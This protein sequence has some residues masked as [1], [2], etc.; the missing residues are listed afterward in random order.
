MRNSHADVAVVM[1]LYDEA[2]SVGGVLSELTETLRPA[3]LGR[4][5][6]VL[7]DDGSTDGSIAAARKTWEGLS[8]GDLRAR[9]HVLRLRAN[10]GNQEALAAGFQYAGGLDCGLIF[11]MDSDGQDDPAAIP[12]MI[13]LLDAH[14]IVFAARSR[15]DEPLLWRAGYT[16]YRLVFR[17]LLGVDFPYGN[18]SG[19]RAEVLDFV[20]E[21]GT[22]RH[23]AAALCRSQYRKTSLKVPRRAR[24]GGARKMGLGALVDHGIAALTSYPNAWVRLFS[25]VAL[26]TTAA[27]GTGGLVVVGIKLTTSLAI[28]GWASVMTLILGMIA[29]QAMGFLVISA[30]LSSVLDHQRARLARKPASAEVLEA[31]R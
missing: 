7:V 20:L 9:L 25:R 16:I 24:L 28:P 14:D 17:A 22:F 3:G 29:F 19:F 2:E 26:L 23:L 15:R 13:R 11:A 1:P 8:F 5:D 18:F 12:E 27:A 6:V 10:A 21:M 4:L 31:R 30:F